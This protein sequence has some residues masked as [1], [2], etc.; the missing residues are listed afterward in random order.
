MAA[1][2]RGTSAP[3]LPT[4]VLAP[5]CHPA[6]ITNYALPCQEL[7]PWV[8]WRGS[9]PV[10]L[11]PGESYKIQCLMLNPEGLRILLS[12]QIPEISHQSWSF[13]DLNINFVDC[14]L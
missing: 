3:H 1:I 2:G 14:I 13:L 6:L 4:T 12:I 7:Q 5:G 11:G 8:M 9:L 10:L